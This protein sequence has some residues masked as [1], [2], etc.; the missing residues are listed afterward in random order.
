M[1]VGMAAHWASVSMRTRATSKMKSNNTSVD[2]LR[3]KPFLSRPT[4]QNNAL[5]RAIPNVE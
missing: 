4:R 3:T 2:G 5:S 1:S